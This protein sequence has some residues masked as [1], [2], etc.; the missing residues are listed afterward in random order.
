M[1]DRRNV[2]GVFVVVLALLF[3][4]AF[5]YQAQATVFSAGGST[6]FSYTGKI[7][8]LDNHDKILT[9]QAGPNDELAFNLNDNSAVMKRS[10]SGSLTDIKIGDLVTVSY[11]DQGDGIYIANEID[12]GAAGMNRC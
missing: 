12:F 8:A 1:F 6:P 4:G 7:V 9:V 2:K 5:A 10:M 3:V 11:F